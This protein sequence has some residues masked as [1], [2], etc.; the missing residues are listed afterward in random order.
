MIKRT[1]S[2]PLVLS[3]GLLVGCAMTGKTPTDKQ[4]IETL[5]LSASAGLK[6]IT[7]ANAA[8]KIT[9]EEFYMVAVAVSTISPICMSA[10]PPT[11]AQAQLS[12]LSTAVAQLLALVPKDQP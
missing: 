10:S 9:A 5:C 6:V 8:G 3:L 11:L 7:A 12:A 2:L 1:I 4:K